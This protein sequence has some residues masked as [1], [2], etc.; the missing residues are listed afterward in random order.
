MGN[1]NEHALEAEERAWRLLQW[2]SAAPLAEFDEALAVQG[3][4]PR[5]KRRGQTKHSML[6][7]SNKEKPQANRNSTRSECWRPRAFSLK[8]TSIHR[9]KPQM[10]STPNSSN[11]GDNTDNRAPFQKAMDKLREHAKTV[12]QTLPETDWMAAMRNQSAHLGID[13][14]VR[15][16]ELRDFLSQAQQSLSTETDNAITGSGEFRSRLI[17][18][19]MP[20]FIKEGMFHLLN[21]E[22][23]AGKSTLI[24]GLFKALTS[25]EQPAS[26]LNVEVDASTNWR[27]FL[28][29]PDMPKE[30]WVLP[31]RNYG[32]VTL[33]G[34][35]TDDEGH[36]AEFYRL[37]KRVA[38]FSPQE[39][40]H[41]LSKAHIDRYAIMAANC[42]ARGERPLF[43]FD[44]YSTLVANFMDISEVDSQFAQPLQNLQ[45]AMSCTGA[46]TIVLHH[47]AKSGISSTASS[48]S[49]TSRLGRIPDV[50]ISM[51]ALNKNSDQMI[52]T[53][54]KRIQSTCLL[55]QQDFDAG[56]WISHGDGRKAQRDRELYLK[57]AA[58]R[59]TPEAVHEK[60]QDL[61]ENQK[62][63][64]TSKQVEI[65]TGKS[66]TT[67]R[68]TINA[69]LAQG[70][71]FQ[72]GEEP[73]PGK[74]LKVYLPMI[75]RDEWANATQQNP[76]KPPYA[77][78]KPVAPEGIN[79]LRNQNKGE[80]AK[81][82]GIIPCYPIGE[83]V[84]I[85]GGGVGK[86]KVVEANLATG[87]H[88]LQ[89][90]NTGVQKRDLRMMDLEPVI[91]E[92]EV[93]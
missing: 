41:S 92:D 90:E 25:G 31:L 76:A 84:T 49:G 87:M 20:G 6:L 59:G 39:A 54:S 82:S 64:F 80:K 88:V 58:L 22:Q 71:L 50:V 81:T 30:S 69:M 60:A 57:I 62:R 79:P 28:I 7:T 29:G 23:G 86:W 53:S 55:V 5:F 68:N 9:Q 12:V 33:T 1:H 3:F 66:A 78:D 77:T 75:C 93:L 48:G 36:G 32:F 4:Y 35:V 43:V 91:D 10:D 70:L 73:T 85:K 27:L 42:V 13:Q 17:K 21:A 89:S 51:E 15:D 67:A 37:D 2:G 24:L 26:F 8:P 14:D 63:G 61:W 18:D 45:R 52:L 44:S 34:Q 11:N 47:T 56:H 83:V 74:Y 65:W 16:G 38:L 72:I 40:N 46:T 19:V